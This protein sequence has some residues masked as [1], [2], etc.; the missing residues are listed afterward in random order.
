M[1]EI[2]IDELLSY[3]I[4]EGDL[5]EE[6]NFSGFSGRISDQPVGTSLATLLGPEALKPNG[7]FYERFS[8]WL[9]PHRIS[10]VRRKGLSEPVS[11]GIEVE[12]L[13]GDRTCSIIG[14]FPS[15]EFKT[16]GELGTS[17]AADAD[18]GGNLSIARD[19]SADGISAPNLGQLS[20]GLRSKGNVG[21]KLSCRVFTPKVMAVG[22]GS[23]RCEW[24]FDVDD[25]PL[26]GRDLETWSLVTLPKSQKTL[27]YRLRFY[28]RTRIAFVP[29][30]FQSEWE[31]VVCELV[32]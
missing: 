3:E 32:A 28:V 26:Y 20:I 24:R 8:V 5:G 18:L 25:A 29:L 2:P 11:V 30:R 7:R 10:I 27:K 31:E 17:F 16:V 1:S 14:L 13:N 4:A 21:L 6:H 12:Y 22:V 15:Y 9:V 19:V 23:S